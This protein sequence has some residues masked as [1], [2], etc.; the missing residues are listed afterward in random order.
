[1]PLDMAIV[2]DDISV[3]TKTERA[4]LSARPSQRRG[5]TLPD[6]LAHP[7]PRAITIG[8][9]A[10]VTEHAHQPHTI[11][12]KCSFWTRAR[13]KTNS[14]TKM[15]LVG[16]FRGPPG[17]ISVNSGLAE[18]FQITPQPLNPA[19]AHLQEFIPLSR[20]TQQYRLTSF[21]SSVAVF[22]A[23]RARKPRPSVSI[24][25]RTTPHATRKQAPAAFPPL[26]TRPRPR[27][28]PRTSA[29]LA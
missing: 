23:H 21:L 27:S 11:N 12:F 7:I 19:N 13:I 22:C 1:M 10:H 5:R 29:P 14:W 4:L 16:I 17:G 3:A 26:I 9:P 15:T 20:P 6:A 18:P 25:A 2:A 24:A 28:V 8:C